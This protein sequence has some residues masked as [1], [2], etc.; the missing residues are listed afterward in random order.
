M[1][2][3]DELA[4]MPEA[5]EGLFA[6]V[7]AEARG[8]EPE[9]WE[10]FPGETFSALGQVCHVRDIELDGY[11]NRVARLLKEE[12]PCLV[13]LDSYAI[14]RERRYAEQDPAAA[15]SAFRRARAETIEMLGSVRA[16][17][18]SRRGYFEGYGP[19]TLAGLAHFLASHDRQHLACLHWLLGKIV[20]FSA[21]PRTAPSPA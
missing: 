9:S 18:W 11:R 6:R 13:S 2:I 20:S 4:S 15:L 21:T 5:L 16:A 1:E 10:G 12:Q 14:A 7:P 3:L 19:V 8:W 17:D